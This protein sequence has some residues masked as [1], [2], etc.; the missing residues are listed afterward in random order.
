MIIFSF[1][2][3]KIKKYIK[4]DM[5]RINKQ[6]DIRDCGLYVLQSFIKKLQN[7]GVDIDYLKLKASYGPDGI[8]LACLKELAFEHGLELES[9][10][11][12][13][14][15]LKSLTNSDF[16]FKSGRS[17]TLCCPFKIWRW[18]CLFAWFGSR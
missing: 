16:A 6:E 15:S 2:S 9:Y 14:E 13:F 17:F 7:K 8:N 11:G 1:F 5:M 3:Q 12:D 4:E 10:S 18:K